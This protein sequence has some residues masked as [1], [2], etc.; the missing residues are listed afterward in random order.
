MPQ[1]AWSSPGGSIRIV[2]ARRFTGLSGTNSYELDRARPYPLGTAICD[3]N[4]DVSTGGRGDGTV[5]KQGFGHHNFRGGKCGTT[6]P[7]TN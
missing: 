5:R 4:A 3:I 7:V 6:F 1:G 2:S